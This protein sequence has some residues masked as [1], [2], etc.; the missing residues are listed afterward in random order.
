MQ[1]PTAWNENASKW[2]LTFLTNNKCQLKSKL[3]SLS[4]RMNIEIEW[5]GN[6]YWKWKERSEEIIKI[7]FS[8][9]SKVSLSFKIWGDLP[10]FWMVFIW[11][12]L[13]MENFWL[14]FVNDQKFWLRKMKETSDSEVHDPHLK[15]NKKSGISFNLSYHIKHKVVNYG[16][17]TIME[18]FI[19]KFIEENW[20]NFCFWVHSAEFL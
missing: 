20:S 13:E 17:S 19:F 7:G 14:Y 3:F 8:I 1:F 4:P 15:R 9:F 18:K 5:N 16:K 12:R 11:L 6:D 2:E 10:S